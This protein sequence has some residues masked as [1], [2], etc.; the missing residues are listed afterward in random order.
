MNSGGQPRPGGGVSATAPTLLSAGLG[1]GEE[2][3]LGALA[4]GAPVIGLAVMPWVYG[5]VAFHGQWGKLLQPPVPGHLSL[6]VV[7]NILV[8]WSAI[9]LNGRFD[10]KLAGVFTRT[11]V[12]HGAL[13]FLILVG[14]QWY[15]IPMLL[16][17]VLSSSVLGAAFT[18]ARQR[19]VRLR[20]GVIGPPHEGLLDPEF[21]CTPLA[22]PD[23]GIGRF[24]LIVITT[25]GELP[26][27]WAPTLARALLA[28]K[29]IRHVSEFLEE[30][31]GAVTIEHFDVDHLPE[32]GLTSYRTRK[33]LFDL[34][35]VAALLPVAVP[36]AA[37][38]GLGVLLT[39]GRPVLFVQPRVGLGGRVFQMVK[40]RSMRRAGDNGGGV[41]TAVGDARITPFGRW[42]RRLH[43]DELPQLWN[44][45][46]GDMSL[47][48]PRP[49]QPGLAEA[50]SRQMRSY[51][52]RHLV[53]PGITGWAQVRAG[54]AANL[55][56]TRV[57]L[58]YDLFYIKRISFSLDLQI[59]ARTLWTLAAGGGVR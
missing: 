43:V 34:L 29:R 23:V 35:C 39:M 30:M 31:H 41:A 24:E 28:G 26:S 2:A 20:V 32:G 47:V 53:R 55:D 21:D 38:A 9:G 44:V 10:R 56:E 7:A 52:F 16:T 27:R 12:V 45:F 42:L 22:D 58:R 37:V 49:E 1:L 11:L 17:G 3:T 13:A 4:I 40:L 51:G 46:R 15:S 33:R 18:L 36:V 6:N 5:L 57:K 14:R 54:Y 48:G 59:M 25:D 8:M 50:Y 19:N